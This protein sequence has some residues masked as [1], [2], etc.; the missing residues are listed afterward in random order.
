ML[1]LNDVDAAGH[2][3]SWG[4]PEHL[5]AL[6]AADT[7]LRQLVAALSAR[8]CSR[9]DQTPAA[10]ERVLLIVCGCHG[11]TGRGHGR[12]LPADMEVVLALAEVSATPRPARGFTVGRAMSVLDIAPTVCAALGVPPLPGMRGRCLLQRTG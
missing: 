7:R 9:R 1:Q 6:T 8:V 12:M 5:Q 11:G 2:A 4:S 10:E 3:H